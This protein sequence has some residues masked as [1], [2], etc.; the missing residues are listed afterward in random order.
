ME[1]F[2]D[3]KSLKVINLKQYHENIIRKKLQE[4][5]KNSI[6]N[7]LRIRT[8]SSLIIKTQ[9]SEKSM[10]KI[11]FL[12]SYLQP[13]L[14]PTKMNNS[15]FKGAPHAKLGSKDDWKFISIQSKEKITNK[16]KEKSKNKDV[17]IN[18]HR[19]ITVQNE[20]T[21]MKTVESQW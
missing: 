12:K 3:M 13:Q 15:K 17:K 14:T 21:R 11:R 4:K 2:Q 6:R 18:S 16:D 5:Q 19:T 10:E 7:K 9:G 1:E 20:R 8:D